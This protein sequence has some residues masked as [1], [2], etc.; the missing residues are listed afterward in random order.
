MTR[1]TSHVK[2]NPRLI[3]RFAEHKG[4]KSYETTTLT[5]LRHNPMG[6]GEK[7]VYLG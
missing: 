5:R 7:L 2:S 4:G 3:D 1:N 6:A